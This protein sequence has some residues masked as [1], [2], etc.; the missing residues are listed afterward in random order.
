[1]N[2]IYVNPRHIYVKQRILLTFFLRGSTNISPLATS[3][4]PIS[5]ARPFS[6]IDATSFTKACIPLYTNLQK[7]CIELAKEPG[8][9]QGHLGEK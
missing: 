4:R 7:T 6:P 2:E 3:R 9:P 1:M 5:D 8:S